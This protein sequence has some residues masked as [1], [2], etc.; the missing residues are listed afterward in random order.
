MIGEMCRNGLIEPFTSP[1]ASLVV[2]VRKKDGT[3]RYCV[4]YPRLNDLTK[5]DSYPLPRIDDTLVAIG[6]SKLRKGARRRLH[7]LQAMDSGS[8]WSCPSACVMPLLPC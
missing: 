2:L 4:D 1:W 6:R 8:T 5:K 3:T 7:S